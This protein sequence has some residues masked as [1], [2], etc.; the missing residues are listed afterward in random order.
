MLISRNYTYSRIQIHFF[1]IF[2]IN[3]KNT[4][5]GGTI[6][7][8]IGYRI[9]QLR[10]RD[11]FT[12]Q[13]LASKLHISRPYLA[14]LENG[15]KLISN[16][17]RISLA[18][19]FKITPNYIENGPICMLLKNDLELFFDALLNNDIKKAKT[20]LTLN[21]KIVFYVEQEIEMQ[22]LLCTYYYKARNFTKTEEIETKFLNIFL[23]NLELSNSFLENFNLQ[24]YYYLYLGEKLYSI[25]DYNGSLISLNL[26]TQLIDNNLYLGK[27]YLKIVNNYIKQYNYSKALFYVNTAIDFLKTSSNKQLL[28]NSYLRLSAIYI[29]LKFYEEALEALSIATTINKDFDLKENESLVLQH[30]GFIYSRKGDFLQ[31]INYH[32]DAL[33][34]SM[35]DDIRFF[36]LNSLINCHI[37]TKNFYQ[38]QK[39]ILSAYKFPLKEFEKIII[40][41]YEGEILL[42]QGEERLG[43]K[44]Q[45]IAIDYFIKHNNLSNLDYVYGLLANYFSKKNNH[46]TANKYYKLQEELK[47][48]Q[49]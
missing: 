3:F 27:I 26:L 23:E 4:I 11:G 45:K 13:T 31:A 15:N 29:H 48:V 17:L 44:K 41:S 39:Y 28:S 6:L 21:E 38:A 40:I 7:F 5:K 36:S 49:I 24:K 33:Q 1:I 20:F 46:K 42:N 47:N 34:N 12:Q 8:H 19:I 2:F 22:L 9:K 16:D 25:N 10:L 32:E 14:N 30:K 35:T 37:K 18:N 43:L